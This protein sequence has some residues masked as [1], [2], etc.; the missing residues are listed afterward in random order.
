M[1]LLDPD[2]WFQK[3]TVR[4][5]LIEPSG[6]RSARRIQIRTSPVSGRT[7]RIAFSRTNEAEAGTESLPLPPPD[8]HQTKTC[9]FCFPQ[10]LERTPRIIPQIHPAGRMKRGRSLLFPN[11]FPYG[12][13]S[14]VGLF[15]NV[16]FVEIGTAS[17]QRYTDCLINCAQYLSRVKKHDPTAVY[18]A[19]TQ[20]HLPSAG[21]SLVHPHLQIHA[22]ET[23]ANHHRFLC[24]RTRSYHR[25]E[26]RMLLGDYLAVETLAKERMIGHIGSW[27][28]FAAFAPEGFFE[29]WAIYK[30]KTSLLAL[31]EN[32]WRDLAT[33]MI[34]AQRFYRSLNRNG[35]NFGLLSLETPQSA[36]EL[37]AVMTVRSN[38]APWVRSDHTGFELMLGDMATFT[39]PEQTAQMARRFWR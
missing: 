19:V 3:K 23:P 10:V 24:D 38:Y 8:A 35:Y 34:R 12:A 14:A 1:P 7:S 6:N 13:Y 5:E 4:A 32:E 11:L 37:R 9:P 17:V 27:A 20:N 25:I 16:H 28:W 2:D 31:N 15:D 22:D 36:L 18:M 39:S 26:K 33:G 30:G 29:I 21:G